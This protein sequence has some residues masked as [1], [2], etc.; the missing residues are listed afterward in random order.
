MMDLFQRFFLNKTLV[1]GQWLMIWHNR[2]FKQ[3]TR[4]VSLFVSLTF[5]L[6]YLSFAFDIQ[7]FSSPKSA[8]V[9]NGRAIEIP[10]SLGTVVKR[11][12]GQG[13]A[14][15][16]IQDLHCNAEVQNNIAEI[17]GY[18]AKNNGVGV[19]GVEGAW[20]Q[21]DVGVLSQCPVAQVKNDVGQYFLKAG[22]ITGAEY[23]AATGKYP[24]RLEGIEDVKQY[25]SNRAS[26]KKFL[27]D[28]SQGYVYDLRES[29]EN[30][31]PQ[32]YGET[33][34]TH[35]RHRTRFREGKESVLRYGLYLSG[36]LKKNGQGMEEYPQLEAYVST[37]MDVFEA[38]VD[39]DELYREMD[40]ADAALR[41]GWYQKEAERKLDELENRLDVIEKL[42]N[43]S[44]SPEELGAYRKNPERY[45]VNE[46]IN[47]IQAQ[48][49]AG[50]FGLDAEIQG[51]DEFVKETETFY[52]VADERSRTFVT[53]IENRMKAAQ[54]NV[55]VMITG[56]YHTQDVLAELEQ[57][58]I[59][60]VSV[61]PRI[62]HVDLVNP[63]FSLLKEKRTPLEK[64]LA[65]NQTILALETKF[66]QRGVAA[67]EAVT[68]FGKLLDVAIK[69]D[70][71]ARLVE[72]GTKGVAELKAAYEAALKGYRG[73]K[74]EID[75][76]RA[77]GNERTRTYLLPLKNS[78]LVA[79]VRPRSEN[80]AG[81][82]AVE[83]LRMNEGYEVAVLTRGAAE[84]NVKTLLGGARL[85]LSGLAV[86]GAL[87][88]GLYAFMLTVGS[89]AV[90]APSIMQKFK[91]EIS[92]RMINPLRALR[93]GVEEL[94][95]RV[96]PL[97]LMFGLGAASL[98]LLLAIPTVFGLGFIYLHRGKQWSSGQWLAALAVT[99]AISG[100]FFSIALWGI[101]AASMATVLYLTPGVVVGKGVL[102]F[103]TATLLH[104]L[105]NWVAD[106]FPGLA[107]P[108]LSFSDQPIEKRQKIP[109]RSTGQRALRKL[110]GDNKDVV[111]TAGTIDGIAQM[112]TIY[113]PA[114][115]QFVKEQALLLLQKQLGNQFK[116]FLGDPDNFFIMAGESL[117]GKQGEE[118]LMSMLKAAQEYVAVYFA[119][120]YYV[121]N[122]QADVRA[123]P[124]E[125]RQI[126]IEAVQRQGG[127]LDFNAPG[128]QTL[129]VMPSR[130]RLAYEKEISKA[131]IEEKDLRTTAFAPN[132]W[133]DFN[134]GFM[135]PMTFSLAVASSKYAKQRY[136]QA[137]PEK[138]GLSARDLETELIGWAVSNLEQVAKPEGS[139][140]VQEHPDVEWTRGSD[141]EVSLRVIQ[142]LNQWLAAA[143]D[144]FAQY[145][146]LLES[147]RHRQ[148]MTLTV[149]LE[150]QDEDEA[151][152]AAFEIMRRYRLE[153]GTFEKL[154]LKTLAEVVKRIRGRVEQR[155]ESGLLQ[156]LFAGVIK[157]WGN[158]FADEREKKFYES[159][160][161]LVR[162]LRSL[163]Q[164][165][166]REKERRLLEDQLLSFQ[167]KGTAAV[168]PG[169]FVGAESL[170]AR[171]KTLYS[172]YENMRANW[173]R[174]YPSKQ[175]DQF[176]LGDFNNE[177]IMR[178]VQDVVG[179]SLRVRGDVD[180]GQLLTQLV[181]YLRASGYVVLEN[182]S[183]V[184]EG[185]ESEFNGVY[186][187]NAKVL[188][189][190]PGVY[191]VT[192]G[193]QDQYMDLKIRLGA[194]ANLE[195]GGEVQIFTS[196]LGILYDALT[197]PK[198]VVKKQNKLQELAWLITVD[199][200]QG[201]EK[202]DAARLL[203]AHLNYRILDLGMIFRALA[204][205]AQSEGIQ[206]TDETKLAK[207]LGSLKLS[208]KGE[209]IFY[210]GKDIRPYLENMDAKNLLSYIARN[211][212]AQMYV[213]RLIRSNMSGKRVILVG[214]AASQWL[215]N[216][217]VK[218]WINPVQG[219][220]V[221]E[222][223]IGAALARPPEGAVVLMG[224]E[225][226]ELVSSMVDA[227]VEE[228]LNRGLAK[229]VHSVPVVLGISGLASAVVTL[230]T[231]FVT[232]LTNGAILSLP[233]FVPGI[234]TF[235]MLL[236][237]GLLDFLYIFAV[238]KSELIDG[239]RLKT[240]WSWM[241]NSVQLAITPLDASPT[242]F[243]YESLAKDSKSPLV[244]VL[245][246]A[247]QMH[248]RTHEERP[249][250]FSEFWATWA[251][252]L[253]LASGLWG[254]AVT[255]L[256]QNA[257]PAI[258]PSLREWVIDQT[259]GQLHG[260]RAA[261]ALVL[262]GL[263]LTGL[264][265]AALALV[266]SGGTPWIQVNLLSK[267][268]A[269]AAPAA[270]MAAFHGRESVIYMGG[271]YVKVTSKWYHYLSLLAVHVGMSGVI[272]AGILAGISGIAG[273]PLAASLALGTAFGFLAALAI[274][275]LWNLLLVPNSSG[276][277]AAAMVGEKES[278]LPGFGPQPQSGA[279]T[280]SQ[281]EFYLDLI[282]SKDWTKYR[283]QLEER[284]NKL[285]NAGLL[286][287][288]SA[289][290]EL[291]T[292]LDQ[293]G[294]QLRNVFPL[295]MIEPYYP[296]LHA[297]VRLRFI[298]GTGPQLHDLLLNTMQN[299][300][301]DF[302][303]NT[304]AL[305]TLL[306]YQKVPSSWFQTLRELQGRPLDLIS[307]EIFPTGGGLSHVIKTIMDGFENL[308]ATRID[309]NAKIRDPRDPFG[310]QQ[311]V[312]TVSY[313]HQV[314]SAG[315]KEP[316]D[317]GSLGL[318]GVS[319]V[320][321]KDGAYQW[322][323]EPRVVDTFK[324]KMPKC[325]NGRPFKEY[326][327][328]KPVV[329]YEEYEV[330]VK[331][332]YYKQNGVRV[333]FIEQPEFLPVLYAYGSQHNPHGEMETNFFLYKAFTT[334][335]ERRNQ[336]LK[337]KLGSSYQKNNI[338]AN[339]GQT[340]LVAAYPGFETG[341]SVMDSHTYGNRQF[342][343]NFE[344]FK[345]YCEDAG[346]PLRIA[347]QASYANE[348]VDISGFGLSAGNDGEPH[349]GRYV[350]QNQR[351]FIM[352]Y[353][354][355]V[356]IT[357]N[358][359]TNEMRE[360]I[361]KIG[362]HEAL[363]VSIAN[364]DDVDHTLEPVKKAYGTLIEI[365]NELN[366]DKDGREIIQQLKSAG[367]ASEKTRFVEYQ[368]VKQMGFQWQTWVNEAQ[369]L[370]NAD[371]RADFI[372]NQLNEF[373]NE[374][375]AEAREKQIQRLQALAEKKETSSDEVMDLA[376][377]FYYGEAIDV[378]VAI[379]LQM[380]EKVNHVFQT[381]I[382]KS[383]LNPRNP[384]TV[385]WQEL[386]L[387]KEFGRFQFSEALDQEGIKR[388]GNELYAQF[389]GMGF[390][391]PA[392]L[393]GWSNSL[394]IVLQELIPDQPLRDK[395]I[396]EIKEN[397]R[398]HIPG[399]SSA[400]SMTAANIADSFCNSLSLLERKKLLK[401]MGFYLNPTHPYVMY[402][403]RL[404][405]E[406]FDARIIG[407]LERVA[408]QGYQFVGLARVQPHHKSLEG[409]FKQVI[410]SVQDAPD[411]VLFVPAYEPALKEAGFIGA[412]GAMTPS[413]KA[414]GTSEVREASG[415]LGPNISYQVINTAY[416]FLNGKP[417]SIYELHGEGNLGDG[418][419]E[420]I[421]NPATGKIEPVGSSRSFD[422]VFSPN[423]QEDP[424]MLLDTGIAAMRA[425]K[426][427]QSRNY[428]D[429]AISFV[430]LPW[431]RA[432][433]DHLA[434]TV[435]YTAW[436]TAA[437]SLIY[438]NAKITTYKQAQAQIR[439]LVGEFA[440]KFRTDFPGN[441]AELDYIS[442]LLTGNEKIAPY[443][444][445]ISPRTG[446]S[447]YS[448]HQAKRGLRDFIKLFRAISFGG[449]YDNIHFTGQIN[450]LFEHVSNG[451]FRVYLSTL[452]GEE[453]F[454]PIAEWLKELEADNKVF[455]LRE[456]FDL[457]AGLLNQLETVI[458]AD[459]DKSLSQKY[460]PQEIPL[461]SEI[462]DFIRTLENN[463]DTTRMIMT[464]LDGDAIATPYRLNG[465]RNGD[466]KGLT[467]FKR[468]L[469][470]SLRVLHENKSG[471]S[472]MEIAQ[473]IKAGWLF[474]FLRTLNKNDTNNERAQAYLRMIDSLQE[475]I[476]VSDLTIPVGDKI[477]SLK[478]SLDYFVAQLLRIQ[479]ISAPAL[480]I[481]ENTSES[482]RITLGVIGLF[483]NWVLDKTTGQ[484]HW[485][486]A[487]IALVLETT[488][489]AL[490]V[491]GVFQLSPDF[492]AN[493][494]LTG[495]LSLGI[496]SLA[497]TLLHG[498]TVLVYNKET[499]N[500]QSVPITA[501]HIGQLVILTGLMAA[502]VFAG[503]ALGLLGML[504]LAAVWG[505]TAGAVLGFAV[506]LV[507]HTLWNTVL[508]R[509]IP[510]LASGI[511]IRPKSSS[512]QPLIGRITDDTKT[513]PN[514]WRDTGRLLFLGSNA[515]RTFVKSWNGI[516]Q[517]WAGHPWFQEEWGRDTFI[518]L[519]G[520]LLVE[521]RF[522]DAETLLRNFAR[523]VKNG[524]IP[525]RIWSPA[526]S[527]KNEYN[528]SDGSL[529]FFQAVKKTY[530]YTN[531]KKFLS[532]M[533]PVMREIIRNYSEGTGY[534]RNDRFNPIKMDP[535][536]A[537]IA[538]PAQSTWMDAAIHGK[539]PVTPRNG[540][541]VEIN[542]L[543]YAALKFMEF[544]EEK[545]GTSK[546]SE[547][548]ARLAG[549]VK[550]SFNDKF[551]FKNE[552]NTRAWQGTADKF[553]AEN[554]LPEDKAQE[555]RASVGGVLRDVVEG[556]PHGDAIRPNMLFAVAAAGDLLSWDRQAAVLVAAEADLL[557]HF[558]FRTLSPRDSQYH[559]IYETNREPQDKD[560]A[561]HQGTVWPWLSGIGTDAL[562]NVLRGANVP[563]NQVRTAARQRL[564]GLADFLSGWY[565]NT[566]H[567][568]TWPT[569]SGWPRGAE[570]FRLT[571]PE[572][573]DG[574]NPAHAP[575]RQTPGGTYSQTWS[576]AE[577]NR[578]VAEYLMPSD[579]S[580]G[581]DSA[582]ACLDRARLQYEKSNWW[583]SN[584]NQFFAETIPVY[585]LRS[586]DGSK[587]SGIGVFSRLADYYKKY[588]KPLGIGIMLLLPH[589]AV[590]DQSPYAAIDP[591]SVSELDI[592]WSKVTEV[593]ADLN[594]MA[595]IHAPPEKQ[596]KVDYDNLRK[597]VLGISRGA[598]QA[599]KA[600]DLA[601]SNKR[602]LEFE[603]FE[604]ERASWLP[605][606]CRIAALIDTIKKPIDTWTQDDIAAAEKE[607][608]FNDE[609]RRHAHAQW[610]GYNQLKA[611]IDEVHKAG[612]KVLF[613]L[614][615]FRAKLNPLLWGD[616]EKRYLGAP[617]LH[618]GVVKDGLNER[619]GDLALWNWTALKADDYAYILDPAKYWLDAGFDGARGD[620][621]H[622]AYK[623]Y[624]QFGH[625]DEPEDDFIEKL[626]RV[627]SQNNA[628]LMGEAFE[629]RAPSI[630]RHGI[631]AT[632][633]DWQRMST[634]DDPR[635]YPTRNDLIKALAYYANPA[636][637]P[638]DTARFIGF[639]FGDRWGDP[640]T[641]KE[642]RNGQSYWEMRMP[643]SEDHDYTARHRFNADDVFKA[644]K[645]LGFV[646]EVLDNSRRDYFY[647]AGSFR[648]QVQRILVASFE[649]HKEK[650]MWIDLPAEIAGTLAK[651]EQ[652][653]HSPENLR[654]AVVVKDSLGH[655][656][657][658][659]GYY[660]TVVP[661]EQN[662]HKFER[663]FRRLQLPTV[664]PG[665]AE[666]FTL[667]VKT[668]AGELVTAVQEIHAVKIILGHMR[669][670]HPQPGV[671]IQA[672]LDLAEVDLQTTEARKFLISELAGLAEPVNGY[673][674]AFL[675]AAEQAAM[676]YA[677]D[678]VTA[679]FAE[680]DQNGKLTQYA[681][682]TAGKFDALLQ[683]V[684]AEKKM[685]VAAADAPEVARFHQVL[686]SLK[687]DL[688]DLADDIRYPN[689]SA[690]AAW[691]IA[692]RLQQ[693]GFEAIA[694]KFDQVF[695]I[696]T[697]VAGV[698]F[699][700]EGT[701][702]KVL[703][704]D[705]RIYGPV[706]VPVSDLETRA[707][708]IPG[709]LHNYQ[710][711]ANGNM[712]PAGPF[713]LQTAGYLTQLKETIRQVRSKQLQTSSVF[714]AERQFA[715]AFSVN[716]RSFSFRRI[717]QEYG[718]LTPERRKAVLQGAEDI[719]NRYRVFMTDLELA[720]QVRERWSPELERK[721]SAVGEE[722]NQWIQEVLAADF[723]GASEA[724]RKEFT[725][726]LL[727]T[728][729]YRFD[730]DYSFAHSW[731]VGQITAEM[732][733]VF[734]KA[735]ATEGFTREQ[736]ES[737]L[738]AGLLHDTG[739]ILLPL[740]L[741]HKTQELT[742]PERALLQTHPRLGTK[743]LTA[744]GFP[745]EIVD[746]TR[747]HEWLDG[748]GYP[749]QL[750]GNQVSDISRAVTIADAYEAVLSNR[751][752]VTYYKDIL[753]ILKE[754][755]ELSRTKTPR[756]DIR[757][758]AA[759]NM[760][761]QRQI[762]ENHFAV[763]GSEVQEMEKEKTP[764]MSVA[765]VVLSGVVFT[766]LAVLSGVWFVPVISALL[767]GIQE[768]MLLS[769]WRR[770]NAAQPVG[771]KQ[772][773]WSW[774]I[775]SR[776]GVMATP[777]TR[778]VR[779][780]YAEYAGA[781]TSTW[782]RWHERFERLLPFK[783]IPKIGNTLNHLLV[784]LTDGFSALVATLTWGR[785]VFA[786]ARL[787][788][789]PA[790]T[791]EVLIQEQKEP[792]ETQAAASGEVNRPY[793]G[794]RSWV[795]RLTSYLLRS[796]LF[797]ADPSQAG[798]PGLRMPVDGMIQ[799]FQG[800][801][802]MVKGALLF[803]LAGQ[804][805]KG[806][807]VAEGN[808][809][810]A[811]LLTES[812]Y[813]AAAMKIMA[814]YGAGDYNLPVGL[815]A[816][817]RLPGGWLR[818]WT[819]PFGRVVYND[820]GTPTIYLPAGMMQNRGAFSGYLM[821]LALEYHMRQINA[822]SRR[823]A[824][825]LQ[826]T[827]PLGWMTHALHRIWMGVAPLNYL[828]VQLGK[829]ESRLAQDLRQ[830]KLN[831]A[832]L[833]WSA[834]PSD[835]NAKVFLGAMVSAIQ[836]QE[837]PAERIQSTRTLLDLVAKVPAWQGFVAG[838]RQV[839]VNGTLERVKLLLPR[840]LLMPQT[841]ALQGALSELMAPMPIWIDRRKLPGMQRPSLKM[842][843]AA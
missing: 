187:K 428:D 528:T 58:G 544:A 2:R 66:R 717:M 381:Y 183:N 15:V 794:E 419:N 246:N 642:L 229:T 823:A 666:V 135:F 216:A 679:Q 475:S 641:V 426:E 576:V 468:L 360:I 300:F 740:S 786:E 404:V 59:G 837:Q 62:T 437:E 231:T 492:L 828:R 466:K 536:D 476:H 257:V 81:S 214:Q 734:G 620:A 296:F 298:P 690:P 238:E 546:E 102:A 760:I 282:K 126:L 562:I 286:E 75:W 42:V 90:V 220:I 43:I 159:Q 742:E 156:R 843:Q 94:L 149:Q 305:K 571:L 827:L 497:M 215:P 615:F 816:L 227:L 597:R 400:F 567:P 540:K 671:I 796:V 578:V 788:A 802:Y 813:E 302:H 163:I 667:S 684:L 723:K 222:G 36:A 269:I 616:K 455:S 738:Y 331:E 72:Q 701:G 522:D 91:N 303:N 48:D 651:L 604:T 438:Y 785:D 644:F 778:G 297:V 751:H 198:Y 482:R 258:I 77:Q 577:F 436:N 374:L 820:Q 275:T 155:P 607:P 292:F 105:N 299:H 195:F 98:P 131:G 111:L 420:G 18:L 402:P 364:G 403:G 716:A 265:F 226:K 660:K 412:T 822:E 406:K 480:R 162:H 122:I 737:F 758:H 441:Q 173:H 350:S 89:A 628:F 469:V 253:A 792:S 128:G 83:T 351:N 37:G 338:I 370:P 80:N 28:E 563:E 99:L 634:H 736:V 193:S 347:A 160:G 144:A 245:R 611:A 232:W 181:V 115:T 661:V 213:E 9:V 74:Q 429:A 513:M 753:S 800:A 505:I 810:W 689:L 780:E 306:M 87:P 142:D 754:L 605:R 829:D 779:P 688:E 357:G 5:I 368:A 782:L 624:G 39:A 819:A 814:Q 310:S 773:F 24:V 247:V 503:A 10:E 304:L 325:F 191:K 704:L 674:L 775:A 84:A 14:V 287:K 203:G 518:S 176:T 353:A 729:L 6:P 96:A 337:K 431:V 255:A 463:P 367:Y 341:L 663:V 655:E 190:Q 86:Q 129:L 625:G 474:E 204:W 414:T 448:T 67:G 147:I 413:W 442:E 606:Y 762:E 619:W 635:K 407:E 473:H 491:V 106:R 97:V 79:V 188:E 575:M 842:D 318:K 647:T 657:A 281:K 496:P 488:A 410:K 680:M 393:D 398:A 643:L 682:T 622:F 439:N 707:N 34:S 443:L 47:Y 369:R 219:P 696:E 805:E 424:A 516:P 678:M 506:A 533:M 534:Y 372:Q 520:T 500:Y 748:K 345:I 141:Q 271:R 486:R 120:Y 291:I 224:H 319:Q 623:F 189:V 107:W 654:G 761:G 327:D 177:T 267:F 440:Q 741:L 471:G 479:K 178:I 637:F 228:I 377:S 706:V 4:L 781:F 585:S 355:L 752:Y 530:E 218:F 394:Q 766:S 452:I 51:L 599:F 627:F 359:V 483:Q 769:L 259:T 57:R 446:F 69:Y 411:Q 719:L 718:A 728:L 703:R 771:R 154:D 804:T 225:P 270:L 652:E 112:R 82:L 390:Q 638:G 433:R 208:F 201:R 621:L 632:D 392:D 461:K 171:T 514:V 127:M 768:A 339:D 212:K 614:P 139:T 133:S 20:S 363:P 260:S 462:D 668:P 150:A 581:F 182:V 316:I 841:N 700:L 724:K 834:R 580:D 840:L 315:H 326:Q 695:V 795:S 574:G 710:M 749:D 783:H 550:Q 101:P 342:F 589:M 332:G 485:G 264:V 322:V 134:H 333:S 114:I 457:F 427:D 557:T 108:V 136:L 8:V 613:D 308:F 165:D 179:V 683:R 493:P 207:F 169:E 556:D 569:Y 1:Q 44:A 22:K 309:W 676:H 70:L 330:K 283:E 385:T 793:F 284:L 602:A 244:N 76:E 584:T 593:Q 579:G 798:Q 598:W 750:V 673:M 498:R 317:L 545:S 335:I 192:L 277:L 815:Q 708:S 460:E 510:G 459:Y 278:W 49:T 344:D 415:A 186:G 639:T 697:K 295:D 223:K 196:E 262:E 662:G 541:P 294:E 45:R 250:R 592:D 88:A 617:H 495:L 763:F 691:L 248:E 61:K 268:T 687:S 32:V 722:L 185:K 29:L 389:E 772:N 523:R 609:M 307:A 739:K 38:K 821:R 830:G 484:I 633:F 254:L 383:E 168:V 85:E 808:K 348:R 387:I 824:T 384:E 148:L 537:L 166:R 547:N 30:L 568:D 242:K 217:D 354:D 610:L 64:L 119:R 586:E 590:A 458:N 831:Q 542:A 490:G 702:G 603:A 202:Y 380:L 755:G 167:L 21:V 735:N 677:V 705:D 777:G 146:A 573:F 349:G 53:Q 221:A 715:R 764:A 124:I 767:F 720:E 731:W 449:I 50:E 803:Y 174:Y 266:G 237:G 608:A 756:Y 656:I 789:T 526:E 464:L 600:G 421:Y 806:I 175:P 532:D 280:D 16:Y 757:W 699:Y 745:A 709:Y 535:A 669:G 382:T 63:Y 365:K 409:K 425:E 290:Q 548:Y 116:V 670:A 25:E 417:V 572:V 566:T 529:L 453:R 199:G 692:Q 65:Q 835:A 553:I 447:G 408:Q 422:V 100:V 361:S 52:R 352:H 418:A 612:G 825:S 13:R 494:T 92:V 137:H 206:V 180:F 524:V 596:T 451:S 515:V 653:G 746:G 145:Q 558:G 543:W 817:N 252:M 125:R 531:D 549:R 812:Q 601:K 527:D 538:V 234:V 618:P 251:E 525:N 565:E 801:L 132:R 158:R 489:L 117:G 839:Q 554:N 388:I 445:N 787:Q 640:Q 659:C 118:R 121:E 240:V 164:P 376:V 288:T 11:S 747:H 205:V 323:D 807:R 12:A 472:G 509:W 152:A 711:R 818:Q 507:I 809:A 68:T 594:L 194:S 211:A 521:G 564:T 73:E 170:R 694:W 60:Y 33:L 235:N 373:L 320:S 56:G 517:I 200:S 444:F 665:Q 727:L 256:R 321:G 714:K 40:R 261:V 732:A 477:G 450:A 279:L 396:R 358:V 313:P 7:N 27:S 93:P 401:P 324:I 405:P 826:D 630:A 209:Q 434:G 784:S 336:E 726:W 733:A 721:V 276:R 109:Q 790:G 645:E 675:P 239:S 399:D 143:Q 423:G 230:V 836:S 236:T 35:D 512:V 481:T 504:G 685:P 560:H 478:K 587:D 356:Q 499:E 151:N 570:P 312:W 626:S 776:G 233:T 508:V 249:G 172:I 19:V 71:A 511:I 467:D 362:D 285:N 340:A 811:K 435:V 110:L 552:E 104:N 378:R 397:L 833:K 629:N 774:F 681:N 241:K 470:H 502:A 46:F 712:A 664:L 301:S 55:G 713:D 391:M 730:P 289:E 561:Y 366:Q 103:I 161:S 648:G 334:A 210:Q 23:Y 797:N 78:G 386:I 838:V 184:P 197:R 54:A 799:F 130:T 650:E 539:D 153:P 456:K 631:T 591:R 395:L 646:G 465:Y 725:I 416:G 519:P 375:P 686:G 559:S 314:N 501:A 770:F 636:N 551:W 743:L 744:L 113:G 832:Y 17:L 583:R 328:N 672:L 379:V 791:A 31:K 138:K 273:L 346:I 329:E 274:H 311:T 588:L 272:T 41:E 3:I 555:L 430:N 343:W 454:Q 432:C 698:K 263:L 371:Q 243:L 157:E 759:L 765:N 487:M 658:G 293:M 693:S 649:D 95:F 595:L 123:W 140:L 582:Q 26:V